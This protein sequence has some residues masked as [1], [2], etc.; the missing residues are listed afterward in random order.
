M[1]TVVTLLYRKMESFTHEI[2]EGMQHMS[3][4]VFVTLCE[5]VGTSQQV[6]LRREAMDIREMVTNSCNG[7]LRGIAVDQQF[8]RF[9][10]IEMRYHDL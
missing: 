5:I 7:K 2:C 10:V 6:A 3:E 8:S 4:T 9:G 1:S